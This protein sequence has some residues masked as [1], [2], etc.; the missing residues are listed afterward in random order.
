MPS[1][2][3]ILHIQ[4]A[5]WSTQMHIISIILF[6]RYV[7]NYYIIHPTLK[8]T[9]FTMKIKLDNVCIIYFNLNLLQ[10]PVQLLPYLTE[11]SVLIMKYVLS[12]YVLSMMITLAFSQII[13]PFFFFQG[14]FENL[15]FLFGYDLGSKDISLDLPLT[16]YSIFMT[17]F[18]IQP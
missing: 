6:S 2:K 3:T 13:K 17:F 5:M 12:N 16:K 9:M 4:V 8:H 7:K 10:N 18:T 11:S 1:E 15:L 14:I